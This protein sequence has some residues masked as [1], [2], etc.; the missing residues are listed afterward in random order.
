MY[1]GIEQ[2]LHR[3]NMLPIHF[4]VFLRIAK[5]YRMSATQQVCE[6]FAG[7]MASR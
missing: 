4:L 6:E 5:A 7:K 2:W 3:D 1:G